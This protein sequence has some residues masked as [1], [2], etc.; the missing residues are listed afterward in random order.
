VTTDETTGTDTEM[1]A[2]QVAALL[3]AGQAQVIDVREDYEH[4]AGHI[5]GSR[6]IELPQLPDEA[7]SLDRD[8]PVVFYC[9][10]GDRSSM[11]AEAFK[12]SGWDAHNMAGGLTAWAEAGLPL[13][14]EDG[15]VAHRRPGPQT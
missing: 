9:R 8:R 2:A 6:H 11:P 12:A 4:D 3:D 1:A 13:E 15:T 14:P 7:G 10:S 5:P